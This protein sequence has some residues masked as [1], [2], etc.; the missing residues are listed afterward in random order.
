MDVAAHHTSKLFSL[1][2]LISVSSKFEM[3]VH[4]FFTFIFM[5][6][7]KDKYGFPRYRRYRLCAQ[8]KRNSIS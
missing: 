3:N 1:A 4:A 2:S 6:W 7:A 8:F 5:Y